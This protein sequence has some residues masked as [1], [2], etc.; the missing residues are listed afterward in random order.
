MTK[1]KVD[2]IFRNLRISG[3]ASRAHLFAFIFGRSGSHLKITYL[4]TF[5]DLSSHL[6]SCIIILSCQRHSES[7]R[8]RI[9][10]S[11]GGIRLKYREFINKKNKKNKLRNAYLLRKESRAGPFQHRIAKDA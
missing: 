9:N 5:V 10:V 8:S 1:K 2:N 6:L 4:V 7:A 3:H 11:Q